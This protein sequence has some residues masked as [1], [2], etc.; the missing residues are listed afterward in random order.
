MSFKQDRCLDCSG[1][2]KR[3]NIANSFKADN[4]RIFQ[5][6]RNQNERKRENPMIPTEAVDNHLMTIK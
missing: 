6:Q 3:N 2:E 5:D 1:E 4:Y